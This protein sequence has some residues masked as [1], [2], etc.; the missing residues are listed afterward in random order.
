MYVVM[1]LGSYMHVCTYLNSVIH[2]YAC[3]YVSSEYFVP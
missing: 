3:M 1:Y 2:M